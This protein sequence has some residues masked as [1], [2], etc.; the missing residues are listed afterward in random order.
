MQ[1]LLVDLKYM[2]LNPPNEQG[3]QELTQINE[4]AGPGFLHCK[5]LERGSGAC[6]G[7]EEHPLALTLSGGHP[8]IGVPSSPTRVAVFY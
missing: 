2:M 6:T 3:Q 8:S 7:E 4:R 1:F 5:A